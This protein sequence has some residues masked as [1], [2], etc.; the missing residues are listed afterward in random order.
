[1]DR[2]N[3]SAKANFSGRILQDL[4]REDLENKN[5]GGLATS[6]VLC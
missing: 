6:R 5:A 3:F 1:M 2:V 4:K